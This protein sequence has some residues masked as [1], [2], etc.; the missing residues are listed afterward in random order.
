MHL[1]TLPRRRGVQFSGVRKFT[2]TAWREVAAMIV[3]IA[4]D[5]VSRM[6]RR[7][8]EN[9]GVFR[10]CFVLP[11]SAS[12]EVKTRYPCC[13]NC[14]YQG[15]YTKTECSAVNQD[16]L[17]YQNKDVLPVNGGIPQVE[18]V[19]A[20]GPEPAILEPADIGHHK[21]LSPRMTWGRTRVNTRPSL[22][23]IR[24]SVQTAPSSLISQGNFQA[25]DGL[26]EM[27]DWE[28]A[29]GR[30]R[31]ASAAG[32]ESKS[33]FLISSLFFVK[34][35]RLTVRPQQL[36]SRN[37]SSRRAQPSGSAT[38]LPSASTPSPQAVT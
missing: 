16:R 27:E 19:E 2:D 4:G 18:E 34:G 12:P 1:L 7:C 35:L 31:E 32:P 33:R 17:L 22:P 11:E 30:I 20:D 15:G 24:S 6:C 13:A 21:S 3:H 9:R 29:P 38:M 10:G 37:R 5:E 25:P 36:P 8:R 28:V 14:L 23:Y 26:L